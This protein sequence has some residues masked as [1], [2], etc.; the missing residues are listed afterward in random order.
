MTAIASTP[1]RRALFVLVI[2][3]GS[4]LL[5][6]VQP[7]VARFAL[8]LL[9][10]APNVWNSA[11]LVFQALLLGGYAYAHA[12]SRMPVR[13]QAVW[14]LGLMALAGLTLPIALADLPPPAPGWE[15]LWV[16][17][18]FA[19]TIGPVFLLVSAQASLMQRWFAASRA[20]G[21]PYAL[22]AASNLGSFAGLLTYPLWLEP[23][24]SLGLQSWIWTAGYGFLFVLVA[25][26]AA[27][28]WREGT[29]APVDTAVGAD[30]VP[31]AE[32]V[33]PCR[34][35]M[36]VV[37]AAVPSGLMLSTTTLLTTDIMAMPLLWVIPLGLYL[38]SFSVAFS[39]G[40]D[41]AAILSRYAPLMLLLV[42]SLAMGSGGQSNPAVALAMV[43][44]LF[45]L[46]V[47]LHNRLYLLRPDPSRLTFFYLVVAAGG[48]LG[49]VFTAL[50]APV[51]FDWVFEHAILLLM[52][53]W[54]VGDRQILPMAEGF[55][56]GL[57]RRRIMAGLVVAAVLI[58]WGIASLDPLT[59]AD[60]VLMLV[61]V[62]A[63][64][65]VIA[66]GVRWSFAAI[67]AA[68]MIGNGGWA[69]IG[70]SLDGARTRSY[71]GIYEVTL[72]KDGALRQLTH[73][74]TLHGQQWTDPARAHEP[75]SYYGHSSG[76]GLALDHA[77]AL[78]GPEANI[79]VVGLGTGTLACYRRP[80]QD[81]TFFEIDPTV[82]AYSRDG[83]FTFLRDCAPNAEIV[84]GDARLKL[85]E[86]A[87]GR[88]D[89]LAIDAFSSDSIPMHL[90]TQEAFATYGEALADDGVLLVHVSN[91]YIDLSPMIAA[92]A[93]ADGWHGR[94]RR[95]LT[96]LGKAITPSIW[97]ALARNEAVLNALEQESQ[98]EWEAL[99]PPARRAWTD[100]N[101]SILPLIRW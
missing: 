68:L 21:D 80:G 58:A 29:Q 93:R 11:M 53:A 97:I 8:P 84:I 96:G 82:L 45:I 38:L 88:F 55:W 33:S 77:D 89:L 12:L 50:V 39:Q 14:H 3:T 43:A 44:L 60:F 94:V 2:L 40:G 52:A 37:L 66:L 27:S 46:A 67:F 13:R 76:I 83:T 74:T 19:V 86:Q 6:L 18:L 23:R 64:L 56:D 16:P 92:L 62:M 17:A 90:M 78:L 61:F 15:V 49:G 42:G 54:L 1:P 51:L 75:T 79:G 22:Y 87:R 35:A 31:F 69:T 63:A 24:F 72:A 95:D 4:F 98:T 100:D 10:G 57:P 32:P 25:L 91:R 85:T 26:A 9:G 20:A 101:A 36:W 59:Q 81:W 30:D 48:A 5:F 99:P 47:A 73:G 65:G 70:K 41:W 28:R 71:F 34:I 7:L